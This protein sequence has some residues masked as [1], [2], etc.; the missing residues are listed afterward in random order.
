MSFESS[1]YVQGLGLPLATEVLSARGPLTQNEAAVLVA[2]LNNDSQRLIYS[3]L[4]SIA[5]A[6]RGLE[7]NYTTWSLVKLYYSCFYSVRAILALSS[8]CLY[9]ERKKRVLDREYCREI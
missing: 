9:Y 6:F 2:K 5:D 7:L 8:V 1:V 3:S 4:L